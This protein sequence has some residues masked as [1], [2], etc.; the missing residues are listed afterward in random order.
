MYRWAFIVLLLIS[1]CHRTSPVVNTGQAFEVPVESVGHVEPD[2]G[3][4]EQD[5]IA[6]ITVPTPSI[7]T[8]GTGTSIVMVDTKVTVYREKKT[9]RERLFRGRDEARTPVSVVSNNPAVTVAYPEVTPW[10]WYGGAFLMIATVLWEILSRIVGT[11]TGPMNM[12]LKLLG[13]KA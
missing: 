7:V 5:I 13:R 2:A 12:I 4:K 6:V 1:G 10:W 3:R 9:I 11:L 8:T